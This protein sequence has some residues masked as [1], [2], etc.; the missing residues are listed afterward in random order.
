M[1]SDYVSRAISNN[2]QTRGRLL[3]RRPV[4]DGHIIF[5]EGEQGDAVFLIE[6]GKVRL[7]RL[8]PGGN[9]IEVAEIG[10]GCI[11]GEMALL[12]GS[13]RMA[14]ATAVGGGVIIGLSQ[15]EIDARLQAIDR[16]TRKT[17]EL[18]LRYIRTTAPYKDRAVAGTGAETELDRLARR[19]LQS[20]VVQAATEVSDRFLAAMFD[21]LT[22]YV[23]LRLPPK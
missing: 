21:V 10:P 8:N 7:T 15:A 16:S 13:P 12:D 18:L 11:F 20:G 14:T 2:R 4:Y 19:T 5:R 9:E 22:G 1:E 23:K 17:F 6:A 3:D